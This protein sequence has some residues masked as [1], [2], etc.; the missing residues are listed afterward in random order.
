MTRRVGALLGAAAVAVIAAG[1]LYG[2]RLLRRASFFRVREIEV[3]G[4]HYLDEH[5]VVARLQLARTASLLDPVGHALRAAEAIPGVVAA[6]V[7]KRYP[8]TLRVEV[9]EAMPV[10]LAAQ[11]ER[12][13]LLDQWGH[14]LPFDPIRVPVSLPII[15]PDSAIAALLARVMVHDSAWF[16]NIERA[17]RDGSDVVFEE[18]K[19]QIRIRESATPMTLRSISA[20]RSY[21]DQRGV[22]WREIDARYQGRVF[23]RKGS[24]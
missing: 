21:L 15:T 12:L 5:D 19:H 13:V 6:S 23:V 14:V 24:A 8:A 4:T 3:V 11:P 7:Q 16:A 17:H 22:P 18:G 2:P 20:V 1:A 9:L 10:A